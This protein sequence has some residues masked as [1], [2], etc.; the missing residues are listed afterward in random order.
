MKIDFEEELPRI[1]SAA[2]CEPARETLLVREK[3]V[4]RAGDALAAPSKT[5][6]YDWWRRHDQH[7]GGRPAG[8]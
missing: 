5:P 3:A 7:G 4:T 6:P 8:A 2:E 1:V